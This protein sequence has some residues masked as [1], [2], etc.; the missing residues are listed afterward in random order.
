MDVQLVLVDRHEWNRDEAGCEAWR[1]LRDWNLTMMR[2][3]VEPKATRPEIS[4]LPEN[5]NKL[6]LHICYVYLASSKNH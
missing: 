1:V 3:V 2:C 4:F 6:W 5:D